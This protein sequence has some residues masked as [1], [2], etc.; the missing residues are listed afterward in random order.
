[1]P[2]EEYI[3]DRYLDSPKV[4]KIHDD[5][6][7][8]PGREFWEGPSGRVTT[9]SRKNSVTQET[10][11]TP[12]YLESRGYTGVRQGASGDESPSTESPSTESP[13]TESPS[14]NESPPTNEVSPG[15]PTSEIPTADGGEKQ[16]A[17]ISE[18]G[19]DQQLISATLDDGSDHRLDSATAEA[20]ESNDPEPLPNEL[21]DPVSK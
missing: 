3:P 15:K 1:M 17:T 20:N 14:T 21:V 9:S 12:E 19:S 8:E 2:T 13:S 18:D 4:R 11:C 6:R 7:N 10:S 16:A 5:E